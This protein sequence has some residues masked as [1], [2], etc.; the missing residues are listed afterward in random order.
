ME[1]SLASSSERQMRQFLKRLLW[2]VAPISLIALPMLI[3]LKI[4]G[5]LVNC[6]EVLAGQV[7]SGSLVALAYSDPTGCVKA[8]TLASRN[9]TVVVLG[10]S[11][12]MQFRESFFRNPTVFYNAGGL[13][14]RVKDFRSFIEEVDITGVETLVIGLDQYFFNEDWDDL[15]KSPTTYEDTYS[16]IGVLRNQKLLRDLWQGKFEYAR[17]GRRGRIGLT[18][19]MYDEGFREDGSYRYGR[20]IDHP[21]LA[22]DVDF[23]NTYKRMRKGNKRFQYGSVV[24]VAAL[25][26]LDSFLTICRAKGIHVVAILPP[27]AHEVWER[28]L[29]QGDDYRYMRELYSELT[30]LFEASSFEL[31]DFSD[32]ASVGSGDAETI[33]G[34]HGSEVAY[35]R[36]TLKLASNSEVIARYVDASRLTRM[37]DTVHSPLEIAPERP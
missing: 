27:F 6:D 9:P 15:T 26:E 5:E 2:F 4:A 32:L 10:T 19:T 16:T 37:L 1:E 20:V 24:S 35:L 8:K 7:S 25:D 21:H 18:A 36:L 34:F 12:V 29:K 30:P 3:S 31:F 14:A 13:V 28:I 17:L 22:W 11:R 33:D 23:E